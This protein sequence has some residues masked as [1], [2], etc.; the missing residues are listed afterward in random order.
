MD[1]PFAQAVSAMRKTPQACVRLDGH[2]GVR[3]PTAGYFAIAAAVIT[4]LVAILMPTSHPW[5]PE[6]QRA[7][8]EG[9][10]RSPKTKTW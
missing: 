1:D 9:S 2:F 5:P 6:K 8:Q 3:F 4:I 7:K 10:P